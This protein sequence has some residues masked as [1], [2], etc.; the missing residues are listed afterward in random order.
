METS[1]APL[2]YDLCTE[3]GSL[4]VC[5]LVARVLFYWRC[6]IGAVLLEGAGVVP[7]AEAEASYAQ[8]QT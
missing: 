1:L 4:R 7:E 3:L 5:R 8:H 6:F 2:L